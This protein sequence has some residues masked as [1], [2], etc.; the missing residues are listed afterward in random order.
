[1]EFEIN[2]LEEL[3]QAAE[4]VLTFGSSSRV[5]LFYG[6]MG[7]GK[8]TLIKVICR[9]LGVDGSTSSPTFSIVNEYEGE[10]GPIYHFDLYRLQKPEEAYDLGYE[11]YLWSGHYCF[12]EWPEKAESS[13]PPDAVYVHIHEINAGIRKVSLEKYS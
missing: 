3:R 8:T 4:Q 13:W 10:S 6:E 12:V 5:Y 2:N 1:M 7:A 11:E 9:Q